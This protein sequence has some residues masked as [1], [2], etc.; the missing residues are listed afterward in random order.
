VCVPNIVTQTQ[1]QGRQPKNTQT[2]KHTTTNTNKNTNTNTNTNANKQPQTQ[3]LL[4][5]S[6]GLSGV[7]CS[8]RGRA[9]G[10]AS[11]GV[12]EAASLPARPLACPPAMFFS[13]LGFSVPAPFIYTIRWFPVYSTHT[14]PVQ[15]AGTQFD[16]RRQQ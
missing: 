10:L 7:R 3:G 13:F 14:T 6:T 8:E 2:H 15:L 11:R 12:Q 1:A 16:H 5:L 4:D 9:E